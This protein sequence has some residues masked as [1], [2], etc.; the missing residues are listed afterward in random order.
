MKARLTL[1]AMVVGVLGMALTLRAQDAPAK[2]AAADEVAKIR[3]EIRLREQ[4]LRS[5]YAEFENSLL[6]LKQRLE[7][8]SK[9]EDR[10][11]A[12]VLGKVLDFSKD[13]GIGVQF[14]QLVQ[15]LKDNQFK[16]VGDM[17]IALDRS[18]RLADDLREILNRLR[19]D[20]KHAKLRDEIDLLKGLIKKIEAAILQQQIVQA[21]TD[22][23]KTEPKELR[24]NQERVTNATA[25]IAKAMSGQG[26]QAK[27][28]PKGGGKPGDDKGKTKDIGDDANKA[29]SKEA[30]AD[31]SGKPGDAKGEAGKGKEAGDPKSGA[32]GGDGKQGDAKGGKGDGQ[33]DPKKNPGDKKDPA[34]KDA[35][36]KSS[37]KEATAKGEDKKGDQPGGEKSASKS[38]GE[39]GAK[40]NPSPPG[41]KSDSKSGGK[42]SAGQQAE[43][44]PGQQSQG[45]SQAKPGQQ[46]GDN[47]PGQKGDPKQGNQDPKDNI[48]NSKK[49]VQDA[50][51]K[52]QQAEDKIAKKDN[53]PASG[54]QGEA[55][56]KLEQAKKKLE[57]LLRQLREEELER[58]LAALENRCQKMLAMQLQ[59]LAGTERVFRD[60]ENNDDKKP[61]RQ[62]Q[63]DSI[64]LS[65]Q[66]KDIVLEATKAIEMLEAEGSAVAF[67][68]VF[69]QVRDDMI[70]VQ[71]RLEITD[72]GVV[73]QAIERDIIESLKEMIDALKKAKKELDDKKNPNQPK[74]GQ[75]PPNAD[76]KLLDQIAELKMIRSMQLRVNARTETY[77]KLY[78]PREGEQTADPMIRRELNNLSERQERISDVATRIAKGDNK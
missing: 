53:K 32:K 54:D 37:L 65:D 30:G 48:A 33:G 19:E 64:K 6:K 44:K 56:N 45:Q 15:F 67:P 1:A 34:T 60:V 36:E 7:R 68:E 16:A 2:S 74:E 43:A 76:Q 71:K 13:A 58:L 47:Q 21:Q 38:G 77:G 26:E 25:Q 75:P 14:E 17:K 61:T 50:Q 57:E 22:L 18:N 59:V 70:H 28:D 41:E 5:Q 12:A 3:D 66:E 42:G 46:S 62:N 24:G 29:N 10:D 8:S 52:M 35:G 40:S 78:V 9:Q 55:I 4:I 23:G 73:T 31:K 63:Q 39:A 69:Q 27:G 20:T 11:R 72:V 49:Q 51:E